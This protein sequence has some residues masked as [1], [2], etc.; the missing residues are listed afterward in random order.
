M[1]KLHIAFPA[2]YENN[3]L[4]IKCLRIESEGLTAEEAY[5]NAAKNTPELYKYLILGTIQESNGKCLIS[6]PFEQKVYDK[7]L[8][9]EPLP[10]DKPKKKLSSRLT[11][12]SPEE[13]I[14]Y[15]Y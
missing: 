2:I 7:I 13:V 15:G 1:S 6:V 9:I 14:K 3:T 12:V 4:T 8:E 11:D 10:V 5:I